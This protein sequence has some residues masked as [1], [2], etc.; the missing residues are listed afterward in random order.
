MAY[1]TRAH[2]LAVSATTGSARAV[3]LL[4]PV[5]LRPAQVQLPG[6][7]THV[8]SVDGVATSADGRYLA[9]VL[10][11]PYVTASDSGLKSAV[12]IVWDLMADDR[13]WSTGSEW[14][15]PFYSGVA[16]SPHGDTMYLSNPV[17]A[18]DLRT[19]RPLWVRG[20]DDV[21]RPDRDPADRTPRGCDRGRRDVGDAVDA[22]SGRVRGRLPGFTSQIAHLAFS[23]DG[24]LVAASGRDLI[25][26]WDA[27]SGEVLQR[28]EADSVVTA[29][30]FA[31]G[32]PHPV[33][34]RERPC[35]AA[36]LGRRRV[37]E[38]HATGADR[39]LADRGRAVERDGQAGPSGPPVHL[40]GPGVRGGA[41][42]GR[43][44]HRDRR[45]DNPPEDADCRPA[46]AGSWSP[47]DG[48]YAAGYLEG[49]VQT[50]DVDSRTQLARAKVLPAAI[51][52]VSYFPDARH[53][54]VASDQG[55]SPWSTPP[56]SSRPGKRSGSPATSTP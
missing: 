25:V 20:G 48:E 46:G 28:I 32:R 21:E 8:V 15:H 38:L 12:A 45:G 17:R 54:A 13:A 24:R 52:E 51:N 44:G 39:P 3:R 7:P 10:T 40:H 55:Q 33:R 22:D 53:L 29:L 50:F 9:A 36:G 35:P 16:L 5:S 1:S 19:G 30:T 23:H 34:R 4:D 26:V 27:R 42:P 31:K 18:L 56:P 2:L 14:R 37:P 41:D 43:R 11:T 6:L 47:D 49:W